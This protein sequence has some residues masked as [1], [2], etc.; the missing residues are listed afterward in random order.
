MDLVFGV[1]R[2]DGKVP[3]EFD[4]MDVREEGRLGITVEGGV[5]ELDAESSVEEDIAVGMSPFFVEWYSVDEVLLLLL[6][7]LLLDRRR[8]SL[9]NGILT[10]TM[11]SGTTSSLKSLIIA[12]IRVRG[13]RLGARCVRHS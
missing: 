6:R 13:E 3:F 2:T 5:L 12:I 1:A 8:S 10:T 7:K 11:G 4:L 9:K